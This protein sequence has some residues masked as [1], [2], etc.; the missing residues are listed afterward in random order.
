MICRHTLVDICQIIMISFHDFTDYIRCHDLPVFWHSYVS[1]DPLR[2]MIAPELTH[3]QHSRRAG[4]R[5][6]PYEGT[7]GQ[8]SG[9]YKL[10]VRKVCIYIY[11]YTY[12]FM[13]LYIY[14]YIHIT[15]IHVISMS[16]CAWIVLSMNNSMKCCIK[17]TRG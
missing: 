2:L 13:Y 8:A 3:L 10:N 5:I 12:L 6:V 4:L 9:Q 17:K 7:H 14:I 15:Y 16:I 11:T 1:Y